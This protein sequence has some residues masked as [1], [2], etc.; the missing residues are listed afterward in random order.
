MPTVSLPAGYVVVSAA[1]AN[2]IAAARAAESSSQELQE[3][4][5]RNKELQNQYQAFLQE[6]RDRID[7]RNYD[8]QR[9]L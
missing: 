4:E 6:T 1:T 7:D 3:Q 8:V 9:N 2:R 5:R